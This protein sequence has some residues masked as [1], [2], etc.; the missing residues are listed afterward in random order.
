VIFNEKSIDSQGSLMQMAMSPMIMG[1]ILASDFNLN[2]KLA[3][4]MV[5]IG[6]PLSFFTIIFWYLIIK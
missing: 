3:N 5:G 1:A 4:F 2:P 6:I